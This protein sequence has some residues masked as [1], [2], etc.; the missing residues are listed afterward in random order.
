MAVSAAEEGK[1]S[2]QAEQE[3]DHRAGIFSGSAPPDQSL[4]AGRSF[5]EGQVLERAAR[6][7]AGIRHSA[8]ARLRRRRRVALLLPRFDRDL[9][10]RDPGPGVRLQTDMSV[11]RV[12]TTWDTPAGVEVLE[13]CR[14]DER[15]TLRGEFH[16]VHV[17]LH[18]DLVLIPLPRLEDWPAVVG[19]RLRLVTIARG[20]LVDRARS[21]LVKTV[22]L[23]DA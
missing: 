11:G 1:Q 15:P 6:D 12:L 18:G 20:H 4:G 19:L 14:L 22:R 7:R 3:G 5:G 13:A 2:K 8:A 21:V 10:E 9:P 23:V 16:R 17:A